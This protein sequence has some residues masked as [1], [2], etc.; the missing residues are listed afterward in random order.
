MLEPARQYAREKLRENGEYNAAAR[1]HANALLALAEDF[2]SRLKITPDHVWDA[3]V[4]PEYENFRAAIEWALG[5]EGDTGLAQRLAGSRC[6]MWCGYGSGGMQKWIRSALETCD[7]T[8]SSHVRA[9]LELVAAL[10]A[11]LFEL[12]AERLLTVSQ[13]ALL[14]QQA[15]DLRAVS[16]AKYFVGH[17]LRLAGRLDEA[18]TTL[19]EARAAAGSCR[20]QSEYALVTQALATVRFCAGDLDDARTLLVE[21]LGLE[22]AAGSDRHAASAMV[23]LAEVEFATGHIERAVQAAEEAVEFY[24]THADFVH[25]SWAL[26]NLSAYL[27]AIKRYEEAR[28]H[29]RDGLRS[30]RAIGTSR[31][32]AWTLQHIAAIA[33]LSNDRRRDNPM[34]ARSAKLIGFVDWLVGKTAFPRDHTEQEEYEKMLSALR[35]AFDEDELAE[36]MN[37]GKEWSEDQ[38]VTEAL[39]M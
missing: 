24:K 6:A 10:T 29:A 20:A 28:R 5:P 9:K 2:D 32:L 14:H 7:E 12:D 25:L 34:L 19:R 22:R 8:T 1:A 23:T 15:G 39:A 18:E 33:V 38:A 13:R 3:Y 36:F 27:I 30:L 11:A 35:E 16:T 37:A 4:E 21:T 26:S 17:A 31:T